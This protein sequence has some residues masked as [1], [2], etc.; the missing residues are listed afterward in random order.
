MHVVFKALPRNQPLSQ[1][2]TDRRGKPGQPWTAV[3]H[4]DASTALSTIAAGR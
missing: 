3:G 2:Q 4:R 1:E